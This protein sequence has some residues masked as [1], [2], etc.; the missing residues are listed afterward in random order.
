METMAAA[1]GIVW[2][3]VVLFVTRMALRQRKLQRSFESLRSQ[4]QASQNDDASLA[5]AA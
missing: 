1:Y 3:A 4:L 2:L 5:R